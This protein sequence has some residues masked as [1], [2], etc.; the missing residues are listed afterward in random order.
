MT[1]P[2]LKPITIIATLIIATNL[3]TATWF[4][5]HGDLHFQ[6]DIARDFFLFEELSLKKFVLIGARTSSTGIFHGPLWQY[7]NLPAWLLGHGNP[8]IVGWFW[9]LL[10]IL[11]L[12]IAFFITTRLVNRSTA[13]LY[14]I[15]LSGNM[16]F[17]TSFM[18]HSHAALLVMPFFIFSIIQY[19]RTHR[20]SWLLLNL[21]LG[22]IMIQ[23][24]LAIGI[25]FTF[26]SL[27]LALYLILNHRQPRHL[28]VL[29]IL[30]LLVSN[31]IIFDLR[32]QFTL[33]Q[34]I[35]AYTS[36]HTDSGNFNY[37]TNLPERFHKAV[38]LQLSPGLSFSFQ[39]L[40]FIFT[41]FFSVR[42][43]KHHHPRRDLFIILP[44]YYFGYLFLTLIN[45][46]Y[47]MQQQYFPTLALTNLWFAATI[48]TTR[49][50]WIWILP[51]III[52]SNF[53]AASSY[54][55]NYKRQFYAQD[56]TSWK[57]LQSLALDITATE[58]EGFGYFVYSPDVFAYPPR[59]ALRYIFSA[60]GTKAHEYQKLPATYLI[61]SPP[62]P[63]RPDL[64]YD[65]WRQHQVGITAHPVS[66]IH[67]PNG[68]TIEKFHLSQSDI[69]V[70]IN[71]LI[72]VGIHFR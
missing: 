65:W 30:P 33:T 32:H 57:F 25:P 4:V 50:K 26:L 72:N 1:L 9:I 36:P 16:V 40:T 42:L 70:P 43:W 29:L 5:R 13:W 64:S 44:F 11:Y 23:S 21:V 52:I 38:D 34:S 48:T 51:T 63:H 53:N 27:I 14:T 18:S 68:Y 45:K 69:Q 12:F 55:D 6:A 22:G 71:P 19:S 67:Y 8:L 58:A 20:W 54:L 46:G 28:L 10:T 66:T 2:Q 37:L 17:L 56:Q 61:A 31:F 62:A 24:Q 35:L 41:F 49:R 60:S 7:I 39:F 15:L 59:Y 3:F 47:V